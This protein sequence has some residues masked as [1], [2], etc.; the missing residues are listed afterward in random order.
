MLAKYGYTSG[1]KATQCTDYKVN[2][3]SA[4]LFIGVRNES[5]LPLL[6]PV[7]SIFADKMKTGKMK[8]YLQIS[9][10]G[11]FMNIKVVLHAFS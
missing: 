8:A 9:L 4:L 6:I 3:R 7:K 10:T 5:C 1:N 2:S 11:N